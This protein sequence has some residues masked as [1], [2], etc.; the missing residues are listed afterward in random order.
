M[1]SQILLREG[2]KIRFLT[3]I[4]LGEKLRAINNIPV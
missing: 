3:L 1:Q 4:N 2:F